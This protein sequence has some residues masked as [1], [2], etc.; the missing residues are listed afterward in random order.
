M[1]HIHLAGQL[2]CRSD[3]EVAAVL[4]LLPEHI[5]LTRAEAGCIAFAVTP[6]DDPR[7]WDVREEFS[8]AHSFRR[9]QERIGS[10]AWGLGTVGIKREYAITGL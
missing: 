4:T 3:E 2:L 9:H 8:D 1:N 6:T 5:Q 7:I 10:S